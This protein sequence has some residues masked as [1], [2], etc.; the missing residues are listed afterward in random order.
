M[1]E[2]WQT[3][4]LD[5]VVSEVFFG[6]RW[7]AFVDTPTHSHADYPQKVRVRQFMSPASLTDDR[8][9]TFF[10]EHEGCQAD[11]SEPLAYCYDSS[12]GPEMVPHFS[13]HESAIADLSREI[14]SRGLWESYRIQLWAQICKCDTD[15]ADIDESQLANADCQTRCVAA[16]ALAE[17]LELPE[18][19]AFVK[20]HGG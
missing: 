13:G 20:K 12:C 1:I 11:G 8:W 9:K 18:A 7:M 2:M 6:W 19:M 4:G 17:A 5:E 10:D 15:G 14:R 3:T 16:L